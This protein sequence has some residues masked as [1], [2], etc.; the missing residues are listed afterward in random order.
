MCGH[1][2]ATGLESFRCQLEELKLQ[3]EKDFDNSQKNVAEHA[4]RNCMLSLKRKF[5]RLLANYC[6]T[7]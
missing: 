5:E 3:A 4:N 2:G 6:R 7:I 1:E